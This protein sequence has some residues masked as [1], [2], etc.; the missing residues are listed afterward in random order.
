MYYNN[1]AF[2]GVLNELQC[3]RQYIPKLCSEPGLQGSSGAQCRSVVT[4]NLEL[5][6]HLILNQKLI[7]N[8]Q[9][10]QEL[11]PLHFLEKND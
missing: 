3:F 1:T 4:E 6:F 2:T 7:P 10:F 5:I 9:K 11:K 8:I